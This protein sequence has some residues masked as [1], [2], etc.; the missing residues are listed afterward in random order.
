MLGEG[1]QGEAQREEK[2][3]ANQ[4]PTSTWRTSPGC[5]PTAAGPRTEP[6]WLR[7]GRASLLPGAGAGTGA[8]RLRLLL[9]E[10][11]KDAAGLLHA[12]RELCSP[13]FSPPTPKPAP[14]FIT[15]ITA[16]NLYLKQADLTLGRTPRAARN[17]RRIHPLPACAPRSLPSHASR[18]RLRAA[19]P[20]GGRDHQCPP[21]PGRAGDAGSEPP[22]P[23]PGAGE[24][25]T[26]GAA[27]LSS[28]SSRPA[29]S[30]GS[31]KALGL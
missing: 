14:P 31:R 22:L 7:G 15:Q 27:A 25:G 12:P 29:A 6:G 10:A 11:R 2:R 30:C 28:G 5:P 9:S 16:L 13:P 4:N 19:T 26:G 21:G 8:L 23:L 17:A 24:P 18:A 20:G 1:C 3:K